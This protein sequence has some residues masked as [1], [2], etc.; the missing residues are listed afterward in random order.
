M[1][2]ILHIQSGGITMFNLSSYL[3]TADHAAITV[4]KLCD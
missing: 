1:D 3:H 4:L 2:W